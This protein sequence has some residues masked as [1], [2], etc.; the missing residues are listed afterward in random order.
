MMARKTK[1]LLPKRI[2]KVKVAKSVRKGAL[3]DLLTSKA[4]QALIAE[5][6][7][8]VGP[9]PAPRSRRELKSR[10]VQGAVARPRPRAAKPAKRPPPSPNALGE[11]VRSFSEALHR[12]PADRAASGRTEAGSRLG[13]ARALFR[14]EGAKP[15]QPP[16]RSAVSPPAERSMATRTAEMPA[17]AEPLNFYIPQR[18]DLAELAVSSAARDDIRPRRR[19]P[20]PVPGLGLRLTC[21]E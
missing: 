4:G 21:N 17:L 3:A 1:T 12:A 2:G 16:R 10:K 11:A 18:V 5:A 20:L 19:G 13:A 15:T 7:L 9:W 6:V 14:A 8:A